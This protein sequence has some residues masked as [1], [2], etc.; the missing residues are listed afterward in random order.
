MFG[1]IDSPCIASYAIRRSAQDNAKAYPG[2]QKAIERNIYMDYLYLAVSSSNEATKFVH[3]TRKVLATGGFNL[4]KWSSNSQ[5]VFD[6]LSLDIRLNSETSAPQIQKV[7]GLPWFPETDKFVIDQKPF[8]KI[9]LDEKTSQ[10]KLLRFVASIFD[11]LG[12]IAPL[13]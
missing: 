1:A 3:E 13:Q 12:V 11:P 5:Q 9:K 10:R 7:L 2:V 6:L 4:T 8:H